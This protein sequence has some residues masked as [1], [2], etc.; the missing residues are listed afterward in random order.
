MDILHTICA[1]A[2]DFSNLGGGYVIIGIAEKEGK[3]LLPPKG[4]L[5]EQ[6]DKMQKELL[7]LCKQRLKPD[8]TPIVEPVTFQNKLILII[9]CPGGQER[10]YEAPESFRK[11]VP[12]AKYYY[13][14]KFSNTV[15][16]K[17]TEKEELLRFAAVPYDDRVNYKYGINDLSQ[18]LVRSFFTGNKKQVV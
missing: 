16:P 17:K 2:N 13:I 7:N 8:Y 15:K 9:W 18:G 1:F 11:D 4:L 3:P 6:A 5:P 12:V 10:P 14:R